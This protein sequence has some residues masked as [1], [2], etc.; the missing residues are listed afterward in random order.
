MSGVN[1]PADRP[2]F[3]VVHARLQA[4]RRTFETSNFKR[5]YAMTEPV[6]LQHKLKE[7][8]DAVP[9]PPDDTFFEYASQLNYAGNLVFRIA[10]NFVFACFTPRQRVYL[11]LAAM[12][13][14]ATLLAVP[15]LLLLSQ[16]PA[17]DLRA[18]EGGLDFGRLDL[19]PPASAA[20]LE[21]WRASDGERPSAS[22]SMATSRRSITSPNRCGAHAPRATATTARPGAL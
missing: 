12:G 4:A 17:S 15:F 1:E 2:T 7:A 8:H 6:T 16:W 3:A 10:H 9:H 5:L 14:A 13:L 22:T 21:S 20:P 19:Q 18:N 11:S